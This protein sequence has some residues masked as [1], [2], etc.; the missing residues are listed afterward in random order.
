M[1]RLLLLLS[2]AISLSSCTTPGAQHAKYEAIVKSWLG[3]DIDKLVNAW[4]YPANSFIAPNGNKVYVYQYRS[5]STSPVISRQMLD[6][7]YTGP[8]TVTTGGDPNSSWCD[9]F[10]E[11]NSSN[12]IVRWSFK[13]NSCYP[14]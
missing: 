1:K 3:S 8:L 5:G 9:T 4:G 13:G 2:L 10:F 7:P 14:R 12:T 11:V 6:N